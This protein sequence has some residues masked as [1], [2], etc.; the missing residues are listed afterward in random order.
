M[1]NTYTGQERQGDPRPSLH[2]NHYHPAKYTAGITPAHFQPPLH[3]RHPYHTSKP[4]ALPPHPLLKGSAAPDFDAVRE[5]HFPGE[6]EREL[7]DDPD[8]KTWHINW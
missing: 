4:I 5:K 3:Q 1:K 7:F 8:G 6:E 2:P